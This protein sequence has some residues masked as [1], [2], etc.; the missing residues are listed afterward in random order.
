[1]QYV[2]TAERIG[3]EKG[4]KIGIEKGVKKG[5][6]EGILIGEILT[7]QRILKQPVYSKAELEKK[8]LK[9]LKTILAETE[10]RLFFS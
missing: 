5:R 1:M 10:S 3:I 2:T 6:K 4:E 8:T 9:E 7:L